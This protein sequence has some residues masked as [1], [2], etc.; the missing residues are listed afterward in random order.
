MYCLRQWPSRITVGA[1]LPDGDLAN[2]IAEIVEF[3]EA[4]LLQK[5]SMIAVHRFDFYRSF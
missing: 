2:P 4:R 3:Y 5:V 1:D